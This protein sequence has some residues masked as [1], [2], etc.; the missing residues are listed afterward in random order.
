MKVKLYFEP[1]CEGELTRRG[2]EINPMQ[3]R[4]TVVTLDALKNFL[5]TVPDGSKV[6]AALYPDSQEAFELL[7]SHST[8]KNISRIFVSPIRIRTYFSSVSLAE[9]LKRQGLEIKASMRQM[10]KCSFDT[11]EAF[12]AAMSKVP[13]QSRIIVGGRTT[14]RDAWDLLCKSVSKLI[15]EKELKIQSHFTP[16]LQIN[17]FLSSPNRH[18]ETN[19]TKISQKRLDKTTVVTFAA[20][21]E[22]LVKLRS[23]LEEY[24]S[25]KK[26][27]VAKIKVK[28][29]YD[30]SEIQALKERL[31]PLE[32]VRITVKFPSNKV[33]GSHGFDFRK[34]I[35]F[36]GFTGE[37]NLNNLL[38]GFNLNH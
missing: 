37:K 29:N 22:A 26:E 24:R 6:G 21:D 38:R 33:S 12:E 4:C 16:K 30:D 5:E 3:Y 7:D 11:V 8:T 25:M 1:K 28:G 32:D 2:F 17:V 27:V 20:L 9:N 13:N 19:G 35:D 15:E 23:R 34:H 18:L 36:L 31:A 14:K 10:Y